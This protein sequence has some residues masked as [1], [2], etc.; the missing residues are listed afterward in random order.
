MN[1]NSF[2]LTNLLFLVLAITSFHL[3]TYS[4]KTVTRSE[5]NLIENNEQGCT[6]KPSSKYC[7]VFHY[8]DAYVV[9]NTEAF[10][11]EWLKREEPNRTLKLFSGD[12]ISP[13]FASFF[14]KGA[15]F[16]K[17]FEKAKLDFAVIG[18]HEMDLG[19]DHFINLMK[20][21]PKPVWMMANI[22]NKA[23]GKFLG[24]AIAYGWKKFNNL[25]I[26]VFGLA[27]QDWMNSSSL[28]P[29]EYIYED[30]QKK[31]VEISRLLRSKGADIVIA[32]THMT[33]SDD[34]ILLNDPDND[35]DIVFGG[36]NHDYLIQRVSQ[37]LLIKSGVDFKFFSDIRLE[38][39]NRPLSTQTRGPNN[40][41]NFNFLLTSSNNLPA[42]KWQFSLQQSDNKFLN[43]QIEK[44][45]IDVTNGPKDP[46]LVAY[47]QQIL[48]EIN[49]KLDVPMFLMTNPQTTISSTIRTREESFPDFLADLVRSYTNADIVVV[50][51]GQI[52]SNTLY[53]ANY[54]Y[55]V[56][57]GVG[58]LPFP[59]TF[60]VKKAKGSD[61][62]KILEQGVQSL[63]DAKGAF[64]VTSGAAFTFNPSNPPLSRI[65]PGTLT[66]GGKAF[67]PNKE[68]TITAGEF[69]IGG[70]D[71]Y[72][73]FPKLPV[74]ESA[75]SPKALFN[76][77]KDFANVP[78]S[79]ASRDE[80]ELFKATFPAL[81][82]N[83]LV[84]FDNQST[85]K[86][87]DYLNQL[88]INTETSANVLKFMTSEAMIRLKWYTLADALNT[89]NSMPI[90]DISPDVDGRMTKT[91]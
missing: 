77:L 75:N 35:I 29:N 12:T 51:S 73:E 89:V 55:K 26:G 5:R 84:N 53:P 41:E 6:Y 9:Q 65:V 68:Y 32:V 25:K 52:R 8:N 24:N 66:I 58:T 56:L 20:N 82:I 74:V 67:D 59:D 88:A 50:N 63:P 91:V 49:S 90:F 72:S 42:Q 17:F 11:Y 83:D 44:V 46:E 60:L 78:Q 79:D 80:F 4:R 38:L 76:I 33:T 70:G 34:L 16:N 48:G 45:N 19:E 87:Y 7:K 2:L 47:N 1:K 3:E 14:Y 31:A 62:L 15:Q 61:I 69:I 28:K 54:I 86:K 64:M 43:V 81:K 36:H 27:D 85:L 23:T 57:D 21:I 40:S 30:F 10:M 39:N 18:N 22:K 71:N 37:K 13:S